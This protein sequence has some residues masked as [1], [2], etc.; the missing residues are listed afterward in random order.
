MNATLTHPGAVQARLDEIERELAVK[1]NSYEEAATAHFRAKHKREEAKAKAFLSARTDADGRVR[2][3]Q[4]RTALAVLE[5]GSIGVE[6]EAR[7]EA[8]KGAVKALEARGT[9]GTSLLKAQ[10][11]GA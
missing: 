7:W 1:Q 10:G 4:E 9:I 3:G 11:R 6:E 5:T 8:L 2:T